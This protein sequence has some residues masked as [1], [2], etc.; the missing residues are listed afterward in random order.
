MSLALRHPISLALVLAALLGTTGVF[1]FA[2]PHYQPRYE[3]EMIDFSK[4]HYYSP[5]VVRS[6]FAAH[7]IELRHVSSFYGMQTYS[8][9][10]PPVGAEDLQVDIGPRTGTGSWGPELEPYDE[11]FGNLLVTYGGGDE[12]LLA[13]VQAAVASLR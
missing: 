13:N 11:R 9:V 4:R 10:A 6:A 3:S 7:G 8:N 2:R 1:V 5:E 12:H